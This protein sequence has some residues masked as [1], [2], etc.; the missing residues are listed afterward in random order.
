[1]DLSALVSTCL[2]HINWFRG[3]QK[4]S[5]LIFISVF[6]LAF[7]SGKS[8]NAQSNLQIDQSFSEV[9][10][11]IGDVITLMLIAQNTGSQNA[12]KVTVN[13]L[14][15]IG[16]KY[17]STLE[18]TGYVHTTG[19]WNI[20]DM[21]V[22]SRRNLRIQVQVLSNDSYTNVANISGAEIESDLTNNVSTKFVSPVYTIAGNVYHD[23]NGFTDALTNNTSTKPL[24]APVYVSLLDQ[25]KTIMATKPVSADQKF[26]F[27]NQPGGFY[28]LVLHQNPSGSSTS[29]LPTGWVNTSEGFSG[30]SDNMPDG[31]LLL[32]TNSVNA[33]ELVFVED[34]GV[35]EGIGPALGTGITTYTYKVPNLANNSKVED[36]FY[37]IASNAQQGSNSWQNVSDHTTPGDGRFLLVNA[38]T[39]PIEFYRRKVSGLL[40]NQ[41]Y[42]LKFWAI[43]VNSK[44]DYDYCSGT[45]GGFVFPNIKYSIE[46]ASSLEILRSGATGVVA[47]AA[48]AKWIEYTF[49]FNTSNN[50]EVDFFL[51]NTAPGG[52]GND[53]GIDD[54]SVRK[55]PT[56]SINAVSADFGVQERPKVDLNPASIRL[57][58]PGGTN[59]VEVPAASFSGTDDG[60]IEFVH[61]TSFPEH[62]NSLVANGTTY[63]KATFPSEGIKV[64]YKSLRVQVDPDD[65][66][67]ETMIAYKLIDNAGYESLNTGTITITFE[68]LSV[69]LSGL[70]SVSEKD[71]L[72]K[73]TITL[74]GPA[75]LVT[76]FPISLETGITAGTAKVSDYDFTPTVITF[77]AGASVGKAEFF[78]VGIKDDA[79]VES[80]EDYTATLSSPTGGVTLVN[81]GVV[82]T[83]KDDDEMHI[84]LSGAMAVAEGTAVTYTATLTGTAEGIQ[85]EVSVG[86]K[87]TDGTAKA[88][89]DYSNSSGQL[90]F[91]AGAVKGAK[92]T[93]TVQTTDDKLVELAETYTAVIS[94]VVGPS[95]VTIETA[96]VV[97]EITDNDE[98]HIVLSGAKAVAE[99]TAVTYTA[100]LTGTAEGIQ[101]EVSVDYKTVDGSAKAG[102]DYTSSSGKLTFAAGAVKGA[103]QT[104]TVQTTDDKLVEPAETYTAVISNA[105]GLSAVT[106]E[107]AEVVTA[108]TDND[109][110]Q[111]VLSGESTVTEGGLAK[112]TATLT[113]TADG[114]QDEVSVDY[115]TVGGSAKA[116]VDYTNSS[117]R[118][119]FAAGAIRGTELSFTV[120]TTD[121]KLV[122]PT[123]SY[124]A[125]ISGS[126]LA[127]GVRLGTAEVTTEITDNDEMRIVLSGLATVAE[128]TAVTYTATLVGTADGIQDEISIEYKTTDGSAKAGL[129]FISSS[130]KLNFPAGA[131]KGAQQTVTVQTLD[132]KVVEPAEIYTAVISNA[133]GLSAVTIETA[134]VVTTITDNDAM[135]IVLSGES[136]VTEGG[137]AKYTATLTGTADGIQDEVSVDYK[138]VDGSAK[139]GADFISSSGKLTFAAGALKGAKQTF[140]VQT[141]DDKLVEPAENYTAVISNAVGFS[142]VTIETAEVVTTITDNDAMQIVLSGA[143][144]VAE[145]TAVTYT[146]MLTGTADGIQDEVSVDYKAVDGSAKAGADYTSSSGKLTFAAGA[147]KG[148]QLTFTVQI[149]DDKLVEPAENYIAVIGGVV[150][151]PAVTIETAEVVTEITDNDEMQIIL[152]GAKTVA[153]GTAVIYTATLMGTAD[154]IQD[155][156]SVDF[157]TTDGTANAGADY[158]SSSGKLTF[159]AGAAK[160]SKLT[161][162]V[163]TTDDKIVE[164]AESYTAI[165]SGVV[166]LPGVTIETP[167]VVTTITD[168]DE[169]QIVLSGATTVAEGNEVI[170]TATLVGTADKI[171]DEISLDFKT[172]DGTAKAGVDFTSSSGKLTF[173]AGAVKGAY[174]TFTVQT[175]D[176]KLVEPAEAYTA[177]ISNVVGLSAVTI[178]TAEV[179]TTITDNDAMQIVLSGESTVTEGGLAKYTATLTGAADGIQDEVSV[180]YKTVDGSAKASADYTSSSGKLTFAAGA[181]KG[182]KQTF[183][184]Q[185][186]DDKL[187]EPAETYTASIS[188]V[189]GLSSVTIE[190]TEVVT[191][192]TDNDAMQIVLSGEGAVPEGGL[193]KYT[194]TLMGTA[195]GIQDEVSLDYSTVDGSAKAGADYISSSGKLTF[196]AGAVNGAQQTFT[197]KTTDD[198]VVEPVEKYT[199][200]ISG[201]FI[202]LGLSLG[203]AEV[204]TEITDNDA[205]QIVLSGGGAVP[206]GGLVKYTATLTGTAEGIQDE[207]S[208]GYKTVDGSAKAGLDYTGLSGKLTFP[209][210]AVK[211]A[212]QTFTVQTTDDKLVE[213]A[214]A[215]TASISNV[216]GLSAVTIETAEVV[217]TITDNDAMQIVL[218]GESTVTEGGLAKYTATL[219]GAADG[220]QDEVS[221]EYKT[222]DG[223]AKASAD[224]TS[225]SGKLTFAAGAVKGAKQ[226]FTIQTTDD[227]L[228]EPAERYT[229][230]ISGVSGPSSVTIGTA[231]VVAEITDN[232]EMQIILTGAKAVAEGT[233]VIYTATLTGTA[234]G[235]Q[236]E[237]SVDFKTTDGSAKAGADYSSLSGKLTFPAGA[238][239]GDLQ[240]FTVKTIDDKIVEQ[241]ER[242]T[243]SISGVRGIPGVT[244]ETA[245]VVTEIIDNDAMQIVLS[246]ASTIAEGKEVIYTATLTGTADGIQDEISVV[247][248]TADGSAKAG[249]DYTS[250]SGK[251][252]FAAGAVKGA[253]Q[254]FTVQ[255]TDDKLVE[256]AERYIASISGFAGASSV[257]I[258]TAEVVTEITDN[259]AMQI[260]LS[261]AS[262]IAEGNEVT[263]I[264]TLTGP[265]EGIQ[266]EISVEYKNTDGTA[267]AGVDY[268][269]LSGKLTF[270]PGAARDSKLSFT[271]QTTDDKL[272]EPAETYT[273]S[274]SNVGGLSAVTI[275]T[276]EVV[277]TITDNDAMQIVLSGEPTVT[278]GGVAK[279]TATLTGTANGIQD[280]ISVDYKI[281]DGTAKA[282][283]DYTSSNSKLTFA[284]G[285]VKGNQL[286]FTVQTTD[287]RI[288]EPAENYTA[289]ISGN[290]IGMG[291]SL[292]TAEVI[293]TITDN[294]EM[295][296]VLSGPVTVN[297]GGSVTYTATLTGDA[298]GIQE[299]VSLNYKSTDGS[300]KAGVD[301]V[302][303]DCKLNFAAG[304]VRGAT[305]TFTVQT[306]DDKVVESPESYTASISDVVGLSPVTTETA[307]II[308]TITD[309][310][311]IRVVLSGPATITE[312]ALASYTV[313]LT[314]AVGVSI[315]DAL[316]LHYRTVDGSAIAG[317]DYTSSSGQLSFAAGAVTGATQI[318]S[319]QTINDKIGEPDESY[320]V[321]LSNLRGR[322]VLGESNVETLIKDANAPAITL[323]DANAI[324]GSPV[325]FPV[326]LSN[327]SSTDLKLIYQLL[328][329]TAGDSDYKGSEVTIIIKAGETAGFLIVPTVVDDL[330]E[331]DETFSI[332]YKQ[333]VSG[334]V[335]STASSATGTI[336]DNNAALK[337]SKEISGNLPKQPGEVLNYKLVLTNT[338]H[339]PITNILVN[340][341]NAKLSRT[342][343][344]SLAPNE[345]FTIDASHILTQS[346]LDEGKVTNQAKA[347]W[348][349]PQDHNVVTLSDDPSTPIPDDPTIFPIK[350]VAGIALVKTGILNKTGT[351]INYTFNLRNTG[352]VTLRDLVLTDPLLG[353]LLVLKERTLLP[354]ASMEMQKEYR[355]SQTEIDKGLI[356]NT[357][358]VKAITP[359]GDQV[360]DV[361]GATV[362]DDNPTI[363]QIG[364]HPAITLVKTG[365]LNA[366]LRTILYSFKVTNTGNVTLY[367]LN[368]R[369]EKLSS[370]GLPLTVNSLV[371]GAS[372]TTTARYT[373]S[374]AEKIDG[375]VINTAIVTAVTAINAKVSDI[376]G[377]TQNDDEPTVVAFVVPPVANDDVGSTKSDVKLEIPLVENDIAKLFP[378]D[379][380][381]LIITGRP[382]YGTIDPGS[383]GRVT[384]TPDK[385]YIGTDRFKYQIKDSIGVSSNEALVLIQ[386][387]P[388]DLEIPN[389]FTPNGDGKNDRFE[390][391]GR[392][393]YDNIELSIYNRWGD[394]VYRS[395]NYKNEWDGSNLN[396]GTYYY[397][398]RLKKGTVLES[399]RSWVLIKR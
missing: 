268:S 142:S 187:V 114:I 255:T 355:L 228:V 259:D 75:G 281:V 97:T 16:F 98:M 381:T 57:Q 319:V 234:D 397:L 180:E 65:G 356:S 262:T 352:N 134:E 154:K 295:R 250:L 178:E 325:A 83:I 239:K 366:D 336:I 348:R 144:A 171:Q 181:V 278:E 368:L 298:D 342:S 371:P 56:I 353:G 231:E 276:A 188:N 233:A 84:V 357:A 257:T 79:I 28:Q 30:S 199:A 136:T 174:Q 126:F 21:A 354:A 177:S 50:T 109:A 269:R 107:T 74:N 92:Q 256:P 279:Y 206:E 5:R 141:T 165:I 226:T 372:T 195:E 399:R 230:S 331:S 283:G 146:A 155:E 242:Y 172:I 333:L 274:I 360:S 202:G 152:T 220:I 121:D 223:S 3:F 17:I 208:V 350:Q 362:Q 140:T 48:N 236:D 379:R 169:M 33:T 23:V 344:S 184:I 340:D 19:I 382:S 90:T 34:F 347:I 61:I 303:C 197:V 314:G 182:A 267:K 320:K 160:G 341:D 86:F 123:E 112:Y 311:E 198:K 238:V 395:N 289:N 166:G 105:V 93:I 221:V 248:K 191:T 159:A 150:G 46:S 391:K 235:I 273:A 41:A 216:V 329:G 96:E 183:T 302:T 69:T 376:S 167:D 39:R 2:L 359:A 89:F 40:P 330:L 151:L 111:I 162:T 271:V 149:T 60:T 71:G 388:P 118:L 386:I 288:V 130:G 22:S 375:Q 275:G 52:C 59:A 31:G 82:T 280:E 327:P 390:I 9:N 133:V 286:T 43:N 343:I 203:T 367:N 88:G 285:A 200:S 212:Y 4:F 158:T 346:D 300:A 11:K 219:T 204:T 217:T 306:L 128:G 13:D 294:D 85:D 94:G 20:G 384:Y 95:S 196:P 32:K 116:G 264:A 37:T 101:D 6:L 213:P 215:Y 1:M 189:G 129:D 310:D 58:N 335:G 373:I 374:T 190:A 153:E 72:V 363:T 38:D 385:G 14:L 100:T 209:A 378:L 287:D 305:Q 317:A 349:D 266:D 358:V 54:I 396:E 332:V 55:V 345:V 66:R 339:V 122:E 270:P 282:G 241:A 18:G 49:D 164:P 383:D 218:S 338:G 313:T 36:G 398:L 67:V 47:Y 143:K 53:L 265:A 337:F 29:S 377:L 261:G 364:N 139:A 8:A 12:T 245:E 254:T 309:N 249:A 253:K 240:T 26:R 361:S 10:P 210:G 252:T 63:T 293:T 157:K 161:F 68:V 323:S 290:F 205:M 15:P 192:I 193:V 369:D 179:V 138:T 292:G 110:M 304:S 124:T 321:S 78:E 115:K 393:N 156:I 173:A 201:S 81:S 324:E 175:T 315:Q 284:A 76:S 214:E 291:V 125:S 387:T 370:T 102:A 176:D 148:A 308:T 137:L 322:A 87:T 232:D 227:K 127:G 272:V 45:R 106:I 316:S 27:E 99:G 131:V 229:V 297:E 251:L 120:Q 77:P 70:T 237:I 244:I 145:G 186:T 73:Y 260:V 80:L 351:S 64:D 258:E 104:F 328:K 312:G 301:Y 44:A 194:A 263:Y 113:G 170:Y 163:Q 222:V 185:T 108:I 24:F 394:E 132:D 296:I 62:L 246:G 326:A 91:A 207:V 135:Q 51:T 277:T 247:Y 119:T 42:Q 117:G 103:E 389:T 392:E 299:S 307:E 35:G 365:V 147:V 25:V 380:S 7:A 334:I 224:Y 211:G 318:F 225:S 168:N 243:G